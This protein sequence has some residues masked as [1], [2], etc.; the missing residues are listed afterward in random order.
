[1]PDMPARRNRVPSQPAAALDDIEKATGRLL[2]TAAAFSD[3][4]VRS[5]SLLPGWCRG[6]TADD[7]PDTFATAALERAV[8]SFAVVPDPS[9]TSV[10]SF[11]S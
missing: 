4:D 5:P 7:W 9:L 10:A 6:F 8:R 3:E 11:L 1:M 2:E